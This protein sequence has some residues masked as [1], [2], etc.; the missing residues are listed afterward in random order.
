M[1]TVDVRGYSCPE[2]VMMTEQALKKNGNQV[3]KV[4]ANEVH[5][6][7]NI[8]KFV[9]SKGKKVTVEENG[10]DFELTIE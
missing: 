5:T 6:K 7:A 8:E 3:I 9:A 2:P 1:V 10:S 4:L